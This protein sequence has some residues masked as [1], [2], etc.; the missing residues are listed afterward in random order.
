MG[1]RGPLVTP[2]AIGE[3]TPSEINEYELKNCG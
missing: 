1:L 3:D 2:K